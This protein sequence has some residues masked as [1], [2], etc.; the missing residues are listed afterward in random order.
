MNDTKYQTNFQGILKRPNVCIHS[1]FK[2]ALKKI[3]NAPLTVQRNV[4]NCSCSQVQG[5]LEISKF[6]VVCELSVKSSKHIDVTLEVGSYDPLPFPTV[7]VFYQAVV[8]HVLCS[9]GLRP[10]Y[11]PS[12]T[13]ALL[14]RHFQNLGGIL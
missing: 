9:A 3:K 1:L 2:Y 11:C 6:V 12:C 4:N 10:S 13:P 8:G 14:L 7:P 5:Q